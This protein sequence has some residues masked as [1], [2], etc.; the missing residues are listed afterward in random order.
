MRFLPAVL[1]L[2]ACASVVPSAAA[3]LAAVDPLTADPAQIAVAVMLPQ[4]LAIRPG[5]AVLEMAGSRGDQRVAERLVLAPMPV[6]DLAVPQGSTLMAFGIAP[7]DAARLRHVQAAIRAWKAEGPAQGRLSVGLGGC[8]TAPLAPDAE[9]SVLVRL[10][11]GG[12][13]RPLVDGARLADLLGPEE[14]AGIG[15]CGGPS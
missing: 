5:T 15:P 2:P 10:E 4:G 13:F 12:P 14:L 1:L 3:R 7:A 9:G 11:E 6:P 8:A